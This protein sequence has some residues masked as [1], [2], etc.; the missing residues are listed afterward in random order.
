MK[1]TLIPLA[2][3]LALFPVGIFF[4]CKSKAEVIKAKVQELV[5]KDQ[6]ATETLLKACESINYGEKELQPMF[7]QSVEDRKKVIAELAAISADG[8]DVMKDS[9]LNFVER[10]NE[11]IGARE[12]AMRTHGAVVAS[13]SQYGFYRDKLLRTR[14]VEQYGATFTAAKSQLITDMDGMDETY[15]IL[16]EMLT[17]LMAQEQRMAGIATQHEVKF[18]ALFEKYKTGQIVFLESGLGLLTKVRGGLQAE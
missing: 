15:H 7:K 9:A 17:D 14:D 18:N 8:P 11:V 2:I 6:A 3:L 16:T 13:N 1:K 12:L 5:A 4:G 10:E